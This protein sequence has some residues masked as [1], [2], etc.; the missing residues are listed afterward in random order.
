MSSREKEGKVCLF[1][2]REGGV[3][4]WGENRRCMRLCAS[5]CGMWFVRERWVARRQR[6][7]ATEGVRKNRSHAVDPCLMPSRRSARH[8]SLFT[9]RVSPAWHVGTAACQGGRGVVLVVAVVLVEFSGEVE[10]N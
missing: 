9:R 8:P 4:E 3:E 1:L 2:Q 10:G 6:G 5:A 7:E